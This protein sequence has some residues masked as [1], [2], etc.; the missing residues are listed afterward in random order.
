MVLSHCRV[1]S[2]FHLFYK[3]GYV[4]IKIKAF[5]NGHIKCDLEI[6]KKN[7]FPIFLF[8]LLDHIQSL[9]LKHRKGLTDKPRILSVEQKSYAAVLERGKK[10]VCQ[11]RDR[12]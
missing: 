5:I 9:L 8:F 4:L 3:N 1:K 7:S 6:Q 11:L 2:F 10:V 12:K